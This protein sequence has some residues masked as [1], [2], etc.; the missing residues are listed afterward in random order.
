MVRKGAFDELEAR[1]SCVVQDQANRTRA[2]PDENAT[3]R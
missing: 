3:V 1:D 2:E